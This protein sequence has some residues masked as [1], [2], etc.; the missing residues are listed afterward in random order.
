MLGFMSGDCGS[1]QS[2]TEGSR[3]DRATSVEQTLADPAVQRCPY[4]FYAALH[5]RD[6]VHYD[7]RTDLWFISRYDHLAEAARNFEVF[8]S[9]ID[10]RRD[11]STVDPTPADEWLRRE[12]WVAPDVLS[13]VD[14]PRHTSF[15][16]LVERLFTG[17]GVKRMHA[18]LDAHVQELIEPFAARGRVDFLNEF[19]IP[20][21]L[22]VIADQL[23]LPREDAPRLKLWT[24]AFVGTLDAMVDA[25]RRLE[26]TRGIVEFQKYFV[27]QHAAKLREPRA[28]LLS[29]LAV[30]RKDDGTALTIEEYL[31]LCAQLVVAGNET[32]R[33]HLLAGMHLLATEPGL[34]ERLRV[35]PGLIPAFVDES[36][37]LESPVQGLFR[38][39]TRDYVLGGVR[40]PAGAKVVLLYGAANRDPAM[41]PEPAK[42]D[43]GRANSS[44]HMSFGFGLHSCIGRTLATAELTIAFRRLLE[45]L[46]SIR[47]AADAPPPR[48]RAHFSLRGL[49]SLEL[50]F[51]PVRP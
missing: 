18:Y 25:E 34:Q 26:C 41:F 9:E 4:G 17:P 47:L 32:T 30:A 2:G 10:M 31:A 48:Q 49:E 37:R 1:G 15:R 7:P 42:L 8:S 23:G 16:R 44:R 12:G 51:D 3:G 33:N 19:A 38:R 13:Q 46:G 5:A 43:L 27:A 35:D 6:P 14:P 24:D 39:C 22:D 11:V 21:P 29:A 50:E 28:D 40:I 45:R 20:L 36:I